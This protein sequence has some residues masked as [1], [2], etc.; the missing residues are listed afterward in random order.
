MLSEP[1]AARAD[2]LFNIVDFPE[3]KALDV[4][5]DLDHWQCP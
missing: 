2:I 3:S 5:Q 1:A 4:L